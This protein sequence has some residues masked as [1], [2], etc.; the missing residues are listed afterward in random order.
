MK[1]NSSL[2]SLAGPLALAGGAAMVLAQYFIWV[3]APV[4]V[5]MG[6]VQKIFYLHLPVAWWGMI[7]FFIVF[8]ASI[9]FLIRKSPG[10]DQLASSAAEVGL[11]YTTLALATGSLWAR[12]SWNTWWTWDPRLSTALIMWFI[13][14]GYLVLRQSIEGRRKMRMVAAVLGVV[15][16]LNVP[17]VFMSARI[18][19]SIHPAVFASEGGGLE[20]EMLTTVIVCVA[21]MGLVTAALI[22]LRFRQKNLQE[23]LWSLYASDSRFN[24]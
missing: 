18:W 9:G 7:C 15:A 5:T 22:L 12:I 11:L 4:E 16:F 1:D 23:R 2:T 14:A 3:Y 6:Q 24:G 8:C 20:P 19:R 13:Y 17:L 21:A 10:M